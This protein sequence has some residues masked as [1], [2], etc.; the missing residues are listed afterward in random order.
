MNGDVI[1][2]GAPS[3]KFIV[4]GNTG[5]KYNVDGMGGVRG[6]KGESGEQGPKGDSATVK[7]GTVTTGEA[8][9]DAI[10]TNS[11]DEH[12]AVLNFTIPRGDT[13]ASGSG[14]G[15]MVASEYDPTNTVK[16]KGGI[17][18]YV[19]DAIASESPVKSVNGHTGNVVIDQAS[20]WGKITG[21]LSDQTD[22][23]S[24]LGAKQNTI[25]DLSAIR[26]GAALG[27][28]ALQSIADGSVT[29]NKI[30]DGAV[31]V[32]KIDW[33]TMP[34]RYTSSPTDNEPT[35]NMTVNLPTGKSSA[36]TL[37]LS[38]IGGGLAPTEHVVFFRTSGT[39]VLDATTGKLS[40]TGRNIT[41][42]SLSDYNATNH[43]VQLS[44]AY[45]GAV[46][47]Q[48]LVRAYNRDGIY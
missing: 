4:N 43:T 36:Y 47:W 32:A 30:A 27:A 3:A 44:V 40:S 38:T 16:D 39:N 46:Y 21:N 35:V 5:A 37:Y 28:T 18:T 34:V 29:S 13:G 11:G 17:P 31:T 24:A 6:P 8:G 2:K 7:I 23:Q 20:E 42:I 10:V 22:L 9:T 48:L 12:D 1:I 26:S 15:D 41:S 33:T 14:T 45:D 25:P 19:S